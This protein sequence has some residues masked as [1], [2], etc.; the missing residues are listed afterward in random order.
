VSPLVRYKCG[1]EQQKAFDEIKQKVS[2]ETLLA[3]PD[4]EKEFHLY[5]DASDK[6]MGAV[7]RFLQQ[8]VKFSTNTLHHR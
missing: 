2:Q 3:F 5:T 4:F 8:K 1:E 7:T 6:K